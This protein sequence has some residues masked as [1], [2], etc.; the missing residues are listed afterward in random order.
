MM[1]RAKMTGSEPLDLNYILDRVGLGSLQGPASLVKS[2]T[3]PVWR[4][5]TKAG[6]LHVK[7]WQ[8]GDWDW[9]NE[10]LRGAA[11]VELA[12]IAAGIRAP[13][14][15]VLNVPVDDVLVTV[16]RWVESRPLEPNDGIHSWLGATLAK[17]HSIPPPEQSPSDAAS[18]Y[19]GLHREEEWSEWVDEAAR[20]ARP[21]AHA[22]MLALPD[23]ATVTELVSEGVESDS[24]VG[25][26]RDLIPQNIL[27]VAGGGYT[28]VDWDLAGPAISWL[29]TIQ[30]VMDLG[31]FAATR[32]GEKPEVPNGRAASSIFAG[33]LNGGGHEQPLVPSALGGTLGMALGRIAFAMWVSLGHRRATPEEKHSRDEY[34]MTSLPRLKRRLDNVDAT[35]VV[36]D[37]ALANARA[38]RP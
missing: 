18:A 27:A 32:D 2:G 20:Q 30:A 17:L 6:V 13:E 34:L 7:V 15:L 19:Y 14:P 36:L 28:L 26:H 24:A 5:T 38:S 10:S 33:Y 12:A 37:E 4:A 23:I 22:A 29:D 8:H 11:E 21:W 3:V 35:L 16:H 25:S 31:R 9:L 1:A